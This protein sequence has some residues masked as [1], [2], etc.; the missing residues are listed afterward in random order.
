M[1]GPSL[2]KK[3]RDLL[4]G[5]ESEKPLSGKE[6]WMLF[7]LIGLLLAVIVFPVGKN[8][9]KETKLLSGGGKFLSANE[10]N[11]EQAKESIVGLSGEMLTLKQYEASLSDKLEAVLSE[12]EGAGR[13][14]VWL[15]LAT[16]S[17]KILYQKKN[18][19]VSELQEQDHAGGTRKESTQ[20]VQQEVL[21]DSSGNPYIIKIVQPQVE[22]VFV[23]AEGAE[24]TIVKKNIMEA[25]QVLFG[26]EAHKIKVA[27]KKV[28]E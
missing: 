17:E 14:E 3:I 10:V 27:K 6:K 15:T 26:I 9:K 19:D 13:V 18:S 16:G 20:K 12:M 1:K 8:E 4:Y 2:I 21:L 23:L 5:K 28:E 11:E 22:G 25:V 24:N 7:L